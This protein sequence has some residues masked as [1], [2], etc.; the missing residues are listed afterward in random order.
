MIRL[1]TIFCKLFLYKFSYKSRIKKDY[2]MESLSCL[3]CG[4]SGNMKKHAR[5][6]RHLV[7]FD[8]KD[9]ARDL[10]MTVTRVKYASCEHTHAL[11]PDF[12]T[13]YSPYSIIFKLR[14]LFL[15]FVAGFTVEKACA[16]GK[17]GI[18]TYYRWL[19]IFE[20]HK[21]LMLANAVANESG[22]EKDLLTGLTEREE[23]SD[24]FNEFYR[25]TGRSFM[26]THRNPANCA[27]PPS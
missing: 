15:H 1:M 16:Y 14:V 17:I 26:Q 5:Y 10:S 19:K 4:S 13:P 22:S 3:T 7:I 25:K 20:S 12:V 24:F 23:P 2:P 9:R 11:L 8:N 27:L 6:S 21:G 18:T